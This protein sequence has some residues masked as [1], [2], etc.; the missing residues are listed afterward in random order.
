MQAAV[1]L[2]ASPAPATPAACGMLL[3]SSDQIL[4]ARV[5]P[6]WGGAFIHAAGVVLNGQ[7][8]LFAGP[9][10][11]GKSTM[12]KIL[13]KKAKILCDDRMIIRREDEG[14]TIHGTWSHG[15]IPLVSPDSAPFHSLFFLRQSSENRVERIEERRAIVQ[16][17]LVRIVRPLV[18]V[19]WWEDVLSLAGDITKQIPCYNLHFDKSGKIADVL[20]DMTEKS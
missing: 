9:S 8:M 17:L 7:G 16:D 1:S 19:D 3:L 12:V 4:L 20:E 11:A 15:E 10:E 2:P 5:L 14:F 13:K 18:T 6:K